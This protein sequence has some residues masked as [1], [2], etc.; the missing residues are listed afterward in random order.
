VA[1]VG[2][3]AQLKSR[4]G[5][6]VFTLGFGSR[7]GA[8]TAARVLAADGYGPEQDGSQIQVRSARGSGAVTGVLQALAARAPDPVSVAVHEPTLDDVFLSLTQGAK[9]HTARTVTAGAMTS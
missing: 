6:V 2:T 8:A 3:P 9:T 1:D 7:D 4:F 5:T